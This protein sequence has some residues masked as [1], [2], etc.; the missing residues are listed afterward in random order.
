M[1]LK[2]VMFDFDGTLVDSQRAIA[3]AMA[4]AFEGAGLDPLARE[5]VRRVVGLRLEQAI[6]DLAPGLS[7]AGVA[8]VARGYREA[9]GTMRASPDF[10]EPLFPGVREILAALGDRPEILL[11][12]ATG[13]NRRGLLHSLEHHGLANHFTVLKTADDGPGKPHPE[14]LERAMAEL[15]VPAAQTV[16]VGD[17]VFDM[18]LARNAGAEAIGVAWGYHESEE[19]L[20]AGAG[21]VVE[22]FGELEARLLPARA[23][24][25]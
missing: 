14:I 17:T 21:C 6:G 4:A 24:P 8:A 13:K 2:L 19:L 18:A 9:F 5:Q 7:E 3:T 23:T 15:G 1:S 12:I 16:M 10:D 20:A 25:R 22:S 11:G